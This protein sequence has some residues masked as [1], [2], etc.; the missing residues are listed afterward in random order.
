V[1][2]TPRAIPFQRV[3]IVGTG[4][5][6]GSLGLALR[7]KFPDIQVTG[8][9]RHH[10]VEHAL[11]S[12]AISQ[13]SSDLASAVRQ[14]DLV[15]VA[16]PIGATIDALPVIAACAPPNALIT[17]S[18]STKRLVCQA[19]ARH[20]TADRAQ[21]LGGHPMAGK[22]TS[23]IE[24]ASADLFHGSRYALIGSESEAGARRTAFADLIRAIGADPI[25][26]DADTHDWAVGIVSHL[27][28]MLAVALAGVVRDETDETGMPLTLAGPGL[29]DSLRLAG[30]PYAVWRDV[31]LTNRENIAHAL[32]RVAQALEHL[33][34]NLGSK[35]LA[36]EFSAANEL[37]KFL[38][39]PH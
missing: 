34:A 20:F 3:T 37:Y 7:D 5:I 18:A 21:F 12:G 24:H 22:E 29:K 26:S 9:D 8:F 4:L 38:N 13:G 30:S 36:E 25:W 17:D 33:R 6:G 2:L 23:G 1:S 14:A 35:D 31:A 27:P 32:D 28:Q 19:A 39:R 11:A 10:V 15:Y 16:L